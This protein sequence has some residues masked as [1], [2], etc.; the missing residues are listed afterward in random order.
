MITVEGREWG[1]AAEIATRLGADITPAMVYRWRDRDGL[2]VHHVGRNAYSPLDQSAT[3]ER[4]KRHNPR[5]RPR[6]VDA[7]PMIAA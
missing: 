5:G 7:R 4:D 1:T 2:T 3:I 6:R